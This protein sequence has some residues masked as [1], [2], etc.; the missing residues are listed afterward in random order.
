MEKNTLKWYQYLMFMVC[1]SQASYG[2]V[3]LGSSSGFFGKIT[4]FFQTVV[5]FLGGA[6]TLFVVFIGASAAI[7]LWVISPK[8]AS[9]AIAW[10][11]RICIGAIALFSLGTFITWL[12][13]F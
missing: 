6:G 3:S 1:Y 13:T 7:F 2:A 9:A 11:F 8:D 4:S 12:G 5:D 10:L